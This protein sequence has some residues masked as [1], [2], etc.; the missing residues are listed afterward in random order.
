[1]TAMG[2]TPRIGTERDSEQAAT[3]RRYDRNA[4]LYDLYDQP[5]DLLGGV[6]RRR[7]R[8][9]AHARGRVLEVGVGTGRN[10]DLYPVGIELT[11]IDVS[12]R[13]LTRAQ[14]RARRLGMPPIVFEQA[15]IGWL[16]YLD[17]TFDTI[18]ATCV[19]CSVADPIAGL[20]ELVR[21]VRHD[22][23]VLLVEHVRPRSR[24]LGRLADRL[25][26]VI[27]RLIG[28]NI[29]R[30][31]ED[32]VFAAGL[33]VLDVRRGGVWREIRAGSPIGGTAYEP[34]PTPQNK[35]TLR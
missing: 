13:M 15:D 8:M 14:R 22:G 5:M 21:V 17:A 4:F 16:P 11:A 28:A 25:N 34:A 18:V 3:T 35:E 29:N 32:N 24:I 23:E 6:R 1:M 26:P 27:V 31:T 33:E 9:L 2:P 12:D 20:A 30:H 7:R 19:F 10:L